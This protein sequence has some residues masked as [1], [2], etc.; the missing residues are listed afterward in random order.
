MIWPTISKVVAIKG[1]EATAGSIFN[2][3]K[4]MGSD[5]PRKVAT[6]IL[7]M[8]V[9]DTIVEKIVGKLNK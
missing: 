1:A 2:F 6:V 9:S 3:L 4:I 8:I 5:A 7:A